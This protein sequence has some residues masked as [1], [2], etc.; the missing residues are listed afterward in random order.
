MAQKGQ[1]AGNQAG[2]GEAEQKQCLLA[3]LPGFAGPGLGRGEGAEA[4]WLD[5]LGP[6]EV[7]GQRGQ[8]HG[9]RRRVVGAGGERKGAQQGECHAEVDGAAPHP[10]IDPAYH[11]RIP[12]VGRFGAGPT[13]LPFLHANRST[14]W[15]TRG[16]TMWLR[17]RN[18][19]AKKSSAFAVAWVQRQRMARATGGWLAG[20]CAVRGVVGYCRLTYNL[21]KSAMEEGAP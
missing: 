3:I 4:G 12:A 13:R 10:G 16:P 14:I 15:G 2:K 21:H 1:I 7:L 19:V 18:P 9:M 8:R 5:W 6:D 17:T 11:A 20:R